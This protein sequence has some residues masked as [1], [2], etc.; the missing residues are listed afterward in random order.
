MIYSQLSQVND[1]LLE[2]DGKV[3]SDM[4]LKDVL[5][6][7]QEPRNDVIKLKLA[8]LISIP[9]R[10]FSGTLRRNN[11]LLNDGFGID[12]T[13]GSSVYDS[14]LV[15]RSKPPLPSPSPCRSVAS[16]ISIGNK[17]FPSSF[18]NYE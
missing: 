3:I 17:S 7:L 14:R 16:T 8:R 4:C 15:H 9:E 1:Q 6:L 2:V 11:K 12:D 18:T 13:Q 5:P 10:D